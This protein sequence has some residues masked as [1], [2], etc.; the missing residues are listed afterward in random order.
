MKKTSETPGR[1]GVLARRRHWLVRRL[2]SWGT[3]VHAESESAVVLPGLQ[4][5]MQASKPIDL[6]VMDVSG[7][8]DDGLEFVH[9]IRSDRCIDQPRS[10]A[11]TALDSPVPDSWHANSRSGR[12]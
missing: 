1:W 2:E 8:L 3:I 11:L 4:R 5:A 10:V 6:I 7:M 9:A 12:P